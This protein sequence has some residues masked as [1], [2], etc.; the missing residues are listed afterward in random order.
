[1]QVE[2]RKPLSNC[3]LLSPTFTRTVIW[4]FEVAILLIISNHH[5]SQRIYCTYCRFILLHYT[6]PITEKP[7]AAIQAFLQ[8]MYRNPWGITN[9]SPCKLGSYLCCRY[10][11]FFCNVDH[12]YT[13]DN[14]RLV[15]IPTARTT[16]LTC[17]ASTSH[18]LITSSMLFTLTSIVTKLYWWLVFCLSSRLS[19]FIML[20]NLS[21]RYYLLSPIDYFLLQTC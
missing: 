9:V 4:L 17:E 8:Y 19:S 10:A 15:T 7:T 21:C 3:M 1:M 13:S 20:S 18:F 14:N 12:I 16:L 11:K 6:L 5:A 2:L